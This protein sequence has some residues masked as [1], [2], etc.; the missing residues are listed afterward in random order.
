MSTVPRLSNAGETIKHKGR[1]SPAVP[2]TI[3][4]A[5]I[6]LVL[7]LWNLLVE[8][9]IIVYGDIDDTKEHAKLLGFKNAWDERGIC[10][11][12]HG[13][14]RLNKK[15][16]LVAPIE[17][18]GLFEDYRCMACHLSVTPNVAGSLLDSAHN[19][20][21]CIKCHDTYHGADHGAYDTTQKGLYGCHGPHYVVTQYYNPPQG[22]LRFLVTYIGGTS[23]YITFQDKHPIY[24]P[25]SNTINLRNLNFEIVPLAFI[26]PA[27]ANFDDIPSSNRTWICLK[28]HFILKPNAAN[29]A[30]TRVSNTVPVSKVH[31]DNCYKC[32]SP[33]VSSGS[34]AAGPHDITKDNDFFITT[35]C[36]NCH[37]GVAPAVG[38]SIH[39]SIGC[40]C[41]TITHISR[42]IYVPQNAA[43]YSDGSAWSFMFLPPPGDYI[44]PSIPSDFT[45]WLTPY[46][47]DATNA[48]ALGMSNLIYPQDNGIPHYINM[49]FILRGGDA[50]LITSKAERFMTCL[51]C[52]FVNDQ[53]LY[54]A[55][56]RLIGAPNGEVRLPDPH[57]ITTPAPLGNPGSE[58]NPSNAS[59]N[60][61]IAKFVSLISA[62]AIILI[63]YV[64]HRRGGINKS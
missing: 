48:S 4:L 56:Q 52:H 33:S 42:Y 11:L 24:N 58:S 45:T 37:T 47:Y 54:A 46:H 12:C 59:V 10:I 41:H 57:S 25:T 3:I 15:Y 8:L 53:P 14:L 51:N 40:R 29:L 2:T 50:S 39:S 63:V 35:A 36:A 32:H 26:D 38:S 17:A 23:G 64:M 61:I 16:K 34:A 30:F 22:G 6:L 5:T 1:R 13:G 21:G 9:S 55:I 60:S 28:C 27:T 43:Q 44:V 19:V 20:I 31:P 7:I 62:F 18:S 49:S